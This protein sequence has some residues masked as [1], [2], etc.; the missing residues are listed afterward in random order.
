MNNT[1]TGRVICAGRIDS[2]G[3][4]FNGVMI[5]TGKDQ[6]IGKPIPLYKDA[7]ILPVNA[8]AESIYEWLQTG[9][10]TEQYNKLVKML[11][12]NIES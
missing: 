5:D 10:S 1:I 3:Y 8:S 7:L 12:K 9:I 2:N 4:F 11:A 6:L